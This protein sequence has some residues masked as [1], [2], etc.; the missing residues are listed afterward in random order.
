MSSNMEFIE[1]VSAIEPIEKART[2]IS[3]SWKL[4][5]TSS[6]IYNSFILSRVTDDGLYSWTLYQF[7]FPHEVH[8]LHSVIILG[9]LVP[10]LCINCWRIQPRQG[11][12]KGV[13]RVWKQCW[14]Y[15]SSECLAFPGDS[16]DYKGS[17]HRRYV[18]SYQE[19]LSSFTS[20]KPAIFAA[21]SL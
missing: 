1:T 13:F 14:Y 20:Q 7:L 21:Q 8:V 10:F 12:S 18:V 15:F 3:S 4:E 17:F 19:K 5:F 9:V 6:V 16:I 2:N 11:T